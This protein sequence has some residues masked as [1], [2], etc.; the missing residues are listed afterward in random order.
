MSSLFAKLADHFNLKNQKLSIIQKYFI[1]EFENKPI[2]AYHHLVKL[3]QEKL[4]FEEKLE[5]E[6]LINETREIF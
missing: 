6:A 1:V 2:K 5:V 4:S 3:Y